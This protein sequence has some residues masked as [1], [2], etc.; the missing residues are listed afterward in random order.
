MESIS[1]NDIM[2]IKETIQRL[3]EKL[4]FK[5]WFFVLLVLVAVI[6]FLLIE[7]I[8]GLAVSSAEK[9]YYEVKPLDE[10]AV[11]D[12]I[13]RDLK[14]DFSFLLTPHPSLL[15]G[16]SIKQ[17]AGHGQTIAVVIENYT[18]IRQ[19]Q[20]GLEEAAIVYET[21]AEG[22]ITRFLAIFDGTPVDVIGP[23]RSARPY[24]ISWA[25]EYRAA[26]VHVGGSPEA[27]ENLKFNF[28]LFNI[29]EFSDGSTI[30]R[31]NKLE[32]PHNA[33]TSTTNVLNRLN[34]EEYYYPIK[35]KRFPFKDPDKT[36]GDIRTITI[37]FSMEPYAVKYVYDPETQTYTRYNGGKQHHDI[38][39]A[40]II[41]QFS[42]SEVLDDVGRLRTQTSGTGK[43]LVFR[44]GKV[45]EGTWEK[46][47]SINSA[48]QA[49][50][51][52]WTKFFDKDGNEI[53]LN[54]GQIWIEVV[55]NG[56]TV[57]YF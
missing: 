34:K 50:N 27:M 35:N 44:D 24:F 6:T 39:P 43:T 11:Y 10:K 1:Y 49:M 5:P 37:D 32:A 23:V 57:N 47:S 12:G 18:P 16:S 28:R 40:D 48:D 46:D 13:K 15:N 26:L 31:N 8:V 21:P 17:N 22:G 33:Y 30:W 7:W 20:E 19:L 56:R 54:K 4:R 29:D 2:Q 3:R 42:D 14:D 51:E 55:P 53:S 9:K 41:V 38:K 25:S 45:I 52:G 36:P